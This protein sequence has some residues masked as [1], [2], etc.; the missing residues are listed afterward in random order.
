MK[1]LTVLAAT[2]ILF[3][4]NN[5]TK[6][7]NITSTKDHLLDTIFNC[8]KFDYVQDSLINYNSKNN[9][10]SISL[11]K[12]WDIVKDSNDSTSSI[13]GA[14]MSLLDEGIVFSFGVTEKKLDDKSLEK[15]FKKEIKSIKDD[16]IL[17]VLDQGKYSTK[18]HSGFWVEMDEKTK[19]ENNFKNLIVYLTNNKKL[20][21]LHFT[22]SSE[23]EFDQK[24]CLVK[25]MIETLKVN[26]FAEKNEL[27]YH[28]K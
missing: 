27:V 11:P 6:Q 2:I 18:K 19:D 4:C 16:S 9:T 8:N 23:T 28:Y 25:D 10:F 13:F 14:D 5:E 26:S 17:S 12:T 22:H 7:I 15:A 21:L 1:Y 24:I 20:Y 3:S